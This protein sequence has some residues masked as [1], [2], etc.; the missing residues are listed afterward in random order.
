MLNSSTNTLHHYS[1]ANEGFLIFS[2]YIIFNL[3]ICFTYFTLRWILYVKLDISCQS[4]LI[5]ITIIGPAVWL[6]WTIFIS[7][8]ALILRI[9]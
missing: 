9:K 5:M 4:W 6:G 2:N 1:L 8:L 7:A 3:G